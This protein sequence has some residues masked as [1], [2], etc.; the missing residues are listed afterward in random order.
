MP[1]N[2]KHSYIEGHGSFIFWMRPDSVGPFLLMT[3]A[4]NTKLEYWDKLSGGAGDGYEAGFGRM[5]LLLMAP[6][7]LGEGQPSS[8]RT[9]RRSRTWCRATRFCL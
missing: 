5:F 7:G 4:N 3:P 6:P 9:R 8:V 1:S 2:F